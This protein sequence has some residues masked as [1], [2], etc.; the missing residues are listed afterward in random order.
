MNLNQ[1]QRR[2]GALLIAALFFSPALWAQTPEPPLVPPTF[3]SL[4]IRPGDAV[5]ITV[6][7]GGCYGYSGVLPNP[8]ISTSGETV[9]A[10]FRFVDSRQPGG[11]P[12]N[13]PVG[14]RF[15][16][17]IFPTAGSYTL[18]VEAEIINYLPVIPIQLMATR[19]VTVGE[20]QPVPVTAVS[21][22]AISLL[23]LSLA[24]GG[25]MYARR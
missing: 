25:M 20:V 14:N 17:V 11:Q 8:I 6:T 13:N 4:N 22:W 10:L 1:F 16:Q 21:P 12:C 19:Q 2:S 18:R 9:T 24:V 23:V 7:P 3:S 15:G 5:T